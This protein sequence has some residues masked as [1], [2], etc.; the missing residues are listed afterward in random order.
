[1]HVIVLHK[2]K[3]IQF[4]VK[5]KQKKRIPNKI[6]RGIKSIALDT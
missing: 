4:A 5:K 1:M 6:P 3:P 2:F